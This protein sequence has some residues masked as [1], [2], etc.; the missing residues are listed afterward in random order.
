MVTVPVRGLADALAATVYPTLPLPVPAEPLVTVIHAALLVAVQPQLPPAVTVTVPVPVP[1]PTET[2]VGAMLKVQA[3][4]CVTVK[5][6]PA[7]VTVPVRE[8][9][10]ALAATLYPTTPPPVPL[11]PLVIV[12]HAALLVAVQLHPLAAVT[13]TLP[14]VAPAAADT[15]VGEM[16]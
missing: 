4:A 10:D 11:A 1:A 15:V 8:A 7:M 3:P 16:A 9:V 5:V 14:D 12:I 6:R 2:P 13:A